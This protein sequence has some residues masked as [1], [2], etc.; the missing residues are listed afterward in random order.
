MIQMR[1]TVRV[2]NVDHIQAQVQ[3]QAQVQAQAQAHIQT[4]SSGDQNHAARKMIQVRK[5][6]LEANVLPIQAQAR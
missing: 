3:V 4:Q 5:V 6:V 1:K 2:K